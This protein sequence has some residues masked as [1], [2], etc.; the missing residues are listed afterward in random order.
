MPDY[1]HRRI[2]MSPSRQADEAW[3]C[4]YHIIEFR[5]TCWGYHKGC[6]SGVFPSREEATAA[7]LIEA[8]YFVDSLEPPAQFPLFK[9]GS[10]AR[11]YRDRMQKLTY[12]FVQFLVRRAV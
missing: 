2:E 8:K 5:P 7:A 4:Q 10:I 11:T 12:S 3:H 9:A 6:T 1:K